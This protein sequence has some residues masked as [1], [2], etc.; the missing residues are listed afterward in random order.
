MT[1]DKNLCVFKSIIGFGRTNES[2]EIYKKEACVAKK[3][4]RKRV[5][6]EKIIRSSL[7]RS[8]LIKSCLPEADVNGS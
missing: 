8:S 2:N 4:P 7:I 3:N 6:E 1:I 5:Y